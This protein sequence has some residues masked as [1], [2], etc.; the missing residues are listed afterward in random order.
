VSEVTATF[1]HLP[2]GW[3]AVP[4]SYCCCSSGG[5]DSDGSLPDKLAAGSKTPNWSYA[6]L[7]GLGFISSS[8][9]LI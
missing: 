4:A 2:S 8:I 7:D 9:F 5:N 6:S 3:S 1:S